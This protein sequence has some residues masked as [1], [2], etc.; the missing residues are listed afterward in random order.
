M[1]NFLTGDGTVRLMG[2]FLAFGIHMTLYCLQNLA[3]RIFYY[4][5]EIDKSNDLDS[6]DLKKLI[7]ADIGDLSRLFNSIEVDIQKIRSQLF[8]TFSKDCFENK[9]EWT[10]GL[11]L[12][13]ADSHDD[14]KSLGLSSAHGKS[15][16]MNTDSQKNGHTGDVHGKA[17]DGDCD[18]SEADAMLLIHKGLLNSR[19]RRAT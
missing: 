13:K 10:T 9:V 8:P 14:G 4:D 16:V 3:L 7:I 18:I 15:R 12:G 6:F 5:I 17:A 1:I 2:L 19:T 11:P